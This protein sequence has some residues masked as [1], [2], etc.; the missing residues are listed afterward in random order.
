M[1][2]ELQLDLSELAQ[3]EASATRANVKKA[4]RQEMSRVEQA[5]Q[6]MARK[7]Q[8]VQRAR[9]EAVAVEVPAGGLV[10]DVL[11]AYSWDQTDAAVK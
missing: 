11:K 6:A 5:V 2:S 4:L 1:E 7:A 3:L 8:E 10:Y 9:E